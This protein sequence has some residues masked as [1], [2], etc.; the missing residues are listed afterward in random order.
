[1]YSIVVCS[2]D[3][4]KTKWITRH[5]K[6]LFG[7]HPYELIIVPDARS[8]AEG[9]N[10]GAR[11][12]R[13][14]VLIFSHDDIEFLAPR[15]WLIRLKEHLQHF[16][17]VGVAG[18]TRLIGPAWAAAGPPYTYGRVGELDGKDAP[19]RMLYCGAPAHSVGGIQALDGLFFAVKRP[20]LERVQFDEVVFDGFHCYDIDFTYSAYLAGFRLG[21]ATDL[22]VLHLSQGQFGK[23]WSVYAERLVQK[24][25]K[26]LHRMKQRR[27][28][29]GLVQVHSKSELLDVLQYDAPPATQ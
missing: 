6:E 11:S 18:T 20:V 2:I 27:Y 3:K 13:G 17:I 5:Y 24:H 15:D 16:D 8:L 9:Y 22:A 26:K 23:D 28:Q 21:V 7:G 25:A 12:A 1:M 19:Y 29:H 14:E 10:R 4:D